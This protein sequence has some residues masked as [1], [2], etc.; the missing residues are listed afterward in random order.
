[1]RK[2]LLHRDWKAIPH[3]GLCPIDMYSSFSDCRVSGFSSG[4][5]GANKSLDIQVSLKCAIIASEGINILQLSGEYIL[6]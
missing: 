1:M 6:R 4:L 2:G 5:M 3:V